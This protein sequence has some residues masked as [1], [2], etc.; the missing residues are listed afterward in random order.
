MA[1]DEPMIEPEAILQH[2]MIQRSTALVPQI[3]VHWKGKSR[4]NATLV[5]FR[6]QFPTFSLKEKA[7]LQG[8]GNDMT[9]LNQQGYKTGNGPGQIR[10]YKRRKIRNGVDVLENSRGADLD[11]R[12]VTVVYEEHSESTGVDNKLVLFSCAA[13]SYKARRLEDPTLAELKLEDAFEIRRRQKKR[14]R[15]LSREKSS[16]ETVC[17][18]VKVNCKGT[19]S[20]DKKYS[21]MNISSICENMNEFGNGNHICS[22]T[23]NV[24][25]ILNEQNGKFE[26]EKERNLIHNQ[27]TVHLLMGFM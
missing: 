22:W 5:D 20:P 7:V 2:R 27:L 24:I 10:V 21:K 1:V 15:S 6:N 25:V 9:G 26:E 23:S 11:N 13:E 16:I 14:M 8:D 18:N 4:E 19:I 17:E 12:M 3:L